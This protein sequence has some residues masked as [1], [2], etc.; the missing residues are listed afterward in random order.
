MRLETGFLQLI[1]CLAGGRLRNPVSLTV[2]ALY[3]L[4]RYSPKDPPESPLK[5]GTSIAS[6]F[7]GGWGDRNV[8][9]HSE[10]CCKLT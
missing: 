8:G 6:L 3:A 10:N 7:K 9:H 4:V 5:R 1:W 2:T